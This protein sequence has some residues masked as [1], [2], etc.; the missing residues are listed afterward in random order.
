MCTNWLLARSSD[1]E[2]LWRHKKLFIDLCFRFDRLLCIYTM[3]VNRA[4]HCQ[5]STKIWERGSNQVSFVNTQIR[6]FLICKR[7]NR[8]RNNNKYHKWTKIMSISVILKQRVF[9]N[10]PQ[11]LLYTTQIACGIIYFLDNR[12][13]KLLATHLEPDSFS[14][15][16]YW[17]RINCLQNQSQIELH[18]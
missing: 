7:R 14:V 1:D 16:I 6:T 17:L 13:W 5:V 9:L 11:S 4:R 15:L 10:W 8:I 18:W 3:K 2:V 12:N